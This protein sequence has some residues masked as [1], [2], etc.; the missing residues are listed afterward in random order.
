MKYILLSF[1][2]SGCV[3]KTTKE[4]G[5]ELEIL[6]QRY[7]EEKI[8]GDQLAAEVSDMARMIKL[9]IFINEE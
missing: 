4:V 1:F 2:L 3:T 8:S 5:Q 9:K 6:A 7:Q